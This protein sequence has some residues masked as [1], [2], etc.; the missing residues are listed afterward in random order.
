[1]LRASHVAAELEFAA[2]PLLQGAADLF[3]RGIESTLAPSNRQTE[4]DISCTD[5][6]RGTPGYAALFDPQTSGGL[7][8]GITKDRVDTFMAQLLE[9]LGLTAV[10]IGCVRP[11]DAAKPILRL[12]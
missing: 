11:A 7:L 12:T 6:L 5:S 2:V 9:K 1:M 4:C 3:A 10:R 8:I